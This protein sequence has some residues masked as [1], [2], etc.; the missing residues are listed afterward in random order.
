VRTQS[1]GTGAE[2]IVRLPAYAR[3]EAAASSGTH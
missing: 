2:V 1:D 3:E